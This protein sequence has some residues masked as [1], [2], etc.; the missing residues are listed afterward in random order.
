[1]TN[2]SPSVTTLLNNVSSALELP[3]NEKELNLA[4]MYSLA[5]QSIIQDTWK[6]IESERLPE[7]DTFLNEL[8]M[9]ANLGICAGFVERS[10][11][12]GVPEHQE[13]FGVVQ[14]DIR[15]AYQQMQENQ[16]QFDAT[17]LK[18]Q[19][20]DYGIQRVYYLDWLLY[21]SKECY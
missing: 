16:M 14:N 19:V 8:L 11:R 13:L 10:L 4:K 3:T 9:L 2:K 20:Y 17:Y 12:P 5:E 15:S 7:K 1:M 18:Y 6:S 21:I